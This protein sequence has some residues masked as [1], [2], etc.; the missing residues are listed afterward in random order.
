MPTATRS[1]PDVRQSAQPKSVWYERLTK[2]AAYSLPEIPIILAALIYT[3]S[4][5]LQRSLG[6]IAFY[7]P[8]A[9]FGAGLLLGWRFHRS[10]LLFAL[11]VL[12]LVDRSLLA[13]VASHGFTRDHV[14]F[15]AIAFLLPLNLAALSL[16]A[17]RGVF[18]AP[19]LVRLGIILGQVALVAILQRGAP[20]AAAAL[21]R[22]EEHTS[23]LQSQSN[24]VCRLLLEKKKE[25]NSLHMVIY[26]MPCR[27]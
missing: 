4:R 12:A 5:G 8:Y 6:A 21:L 15:Q 18:T 9:M 11:L 10:R 19:G 1:S 26:G 24:L 20:G 2:A 23:E 17:E 3:N 7:Y 16:T 25:D 27:T 22:S 14:A 13:F